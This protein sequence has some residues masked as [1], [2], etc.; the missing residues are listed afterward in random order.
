MAGA[1]WL[2]RIFWA[3]DMLAYGVGIGLGVLFDGL[4]LSAFCGQLR[5]HAGAR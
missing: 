3:W 4:A 1:L 2:G 5:R